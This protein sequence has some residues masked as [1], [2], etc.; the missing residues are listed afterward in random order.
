MMVKKGIKDE[1]LSLE[2]V[3][4][5]ALYK[6]LNPTEPLTQGVNQCCTYT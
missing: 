4:H 6:S 1:K 5:T 3:W 2:S